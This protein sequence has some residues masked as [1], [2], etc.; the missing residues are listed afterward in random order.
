MRQLFS[1]EIETLT[2]QQRC[3]SDDWSKILVTDDFNPYNIRNTNF[4]GYIRIGS[5]A[6]ITDTRIIKGSGKTAKPRIISVL[7]EGGDGNVILCPQLTA[8]IAY[9]MMNNKAVFSLV[10]EEVKKEQEKL[11]GIFWTIIGEGAV[12]EGA[13]KIED[14]EICSSADAPTYIGPDVILHHSV[15]ALGATITDGAKVYESF[16]GEAVHIGKGFSSEASLFFA[17]A[18]MD[19]GEAC[20]ALCG[21]FA[22]SHHKSTLLIG[23]EF[24]FYN[25][26]SNTNQSN[27][28]YKM[29]PIHWGT[30]QRGAKTASGCHILWP[31][32]I[33]MFSM[34]MGKLTQHPVIP[35]LPF[36]Y[37]FGDPAKTYVYPAV[38]IK[39]VGTWRD[40]NKWPKRDARHQNARRDILTF[41][42]PNPLILQQVK[43]AINTLLQLQ[44]TSE[45]LPEYFYQNCY[46][47]RDALLKGLEYYKLILLLC[48][49][50]WE[51]EYVDMLGCIVKVSDIQSVI[52][53]VESGEIKDTDTL[54]TQISSLNHTYKIANANHEA[55]QKWMKLVK[56]DA[57]KEFDMGDV[58][59][60]Q[61]QDFVGTL[62]T[63]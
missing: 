24:S 47:K 16:V 51:G 27:H 36:S 45:D 42:F 59:E 37:V 32:T 58:S 21:P 33:G 48:D 25:A 4:Y 3:Y 14:S 57:Q 2:N 31:A 40:I 41:D 17:N 35:D 28:A 43:E 30:L 55:Y 6:K 22:T 46:I 5:G 63:V 12:I 1:H 10:K 54:L 20:A 19:N 18:Y 62:P 52:S 9:L 15:T 26:G 56:A 8:Q 7:N 29:G 34:V 44:S 13:S 11:D 50:A 60:D 39:T 49:P 53:K 38:N 23:G 61:L